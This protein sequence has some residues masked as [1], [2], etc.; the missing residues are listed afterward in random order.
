[1]NIL[2]EIIRSGAVTRSA[3]VLL[4]PFVPYTCWLIG[5]PKSPDGVSSAATLVYTSARGSRLTLKGEVSS[6][7]ELD[8]TVPAT[9][10][11]FAPEYPSGVPV[12]EVRT[13]RRRVVEGRES[14]SF[15]S[16][17][18]IEELSKKNLF[19]DRSLQLK[20]AFPTRDGRSLVLPIRA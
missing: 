12:G 8:D 20:V 11:A 6:F 5:S 7:E 16:F 2:H 4:L 9:L 15:C 19:S 1:G 14:F 10:V 17:I 18:D 3:C 13:T